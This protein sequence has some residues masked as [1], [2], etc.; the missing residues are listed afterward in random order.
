LGRTINLNGASFTVI[1]VMPAALDFP[2]KDVELWTALQLQQPTRRG[3]YFLRGVARLKPGVS[4]E[5]ARAEALNALKSS[6]EGELLGLNVLPVNEFIVGDV[7]LALLVL[8]GAVT[9]VLLIA[10]VNVANL[11]LARSAARVKEISI[12]SALGAGRARIIRQLLTESL[13]LA[14]VGGLLGALWSSWGVKLLLKMAPDSIPRLSQIGIDGRALAWTAL[15][16]LLTGVLFGLAPAW[17]SSRLSLNETLKEGGRSGADSP[18]KR[19]WRDLLVVSELALAVMLL[20]GAGLLVK[21]FWRLQRVD[22]GVDTDRVLTMQLAL[23]G[24]RYADPQQVDAFYPRLLERIQALPGVRAAAASNSLPPDSTEFSDDFTVEGRPAVPKQ[25]P[26]IAYVIRVSPD[27]FRAFGIPLRNGR[28]FSVADSS[29]APLVAVINETMARQFFPN[30]DPVGKRI[31]TGDEREPTLWQI[32]GVVGD[33]KYNGLADEAQPAMYEPLIQATSYNVF[34]S[35]KTE[36]AD[37]LSLAA[38]VRN[39]IR[40]LDRELPVTRV[41]TMEQRI[42]TTVAQPRF[43]ATLVALFAALALILASIGVYGVISYSVT[44]RTQEIGVRVALGARSRDV[45]SLVL[46]QGMTL[47]A[48][49]MGAGLIGSFALTRLMKTLLFDV[50]ATDPLTF[51]LI[52]L[53]LTAVALLACLVPARRATKVDPMIALRS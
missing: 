19:R 16:S 3:P 23:R 20:I 37:P 25:P 15:V 2:S 53:L 29:N 40:S 38:A 4:L 39:E 33:V 50:S 9:L 35:V 31:N 6:F 49:G 36:T 47:T 41:R 30:E 12:R 18:G 13:L 43:G 17:Q 34:L 27:Y 24:E 45:L 32:V 26:P 42:A 5:Q 10:A 1:G 7:R 52:S 46:K 11:T 14:L 22:P 21:S 8:L 51:I 28:Y 48:T 44:Q